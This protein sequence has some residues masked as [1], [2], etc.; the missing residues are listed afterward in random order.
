M[1]EIASVVFAAGKGTRMTGYK[2]N[3]TLLP[4]FAG[5]SLYEG[6]RPLIREVLDNLPAGPKRIVINH[7]AADVRAATR[8][9]GIEYILQPQTNGTGGALLAA[10]AFLESTRPGLVII[11]MGDVPLIRQYT[12]RS[13]IERLGTCQ[14]AVL[15]FEPKDRAQY[16]M[17]ELDG[18]KVVRIV[19]WSEW[20]SDKFPPERREALRYC[21]AGVYAVKRPILLNY[22][23]KLSDRS[24]VVRKTIDGRE[25]AIREYFITDLIEMMNADGLPIG[26]ETAPEEEVIGV[27][28]PESLDL[29]QRLYS[30]ILT[31]GRK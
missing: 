9:P 27:D 28:T 21:N 25:V 7:C 12:Y 6:H 26:Y 30:D 13:L 23:Q 5:A 2:G 15:A 4:L 29:V 8:G 1:A 19:E 17:L 14:M 18:K 11:T 16:G 3:K 31:G 10:R 24:H 20:S 22:I